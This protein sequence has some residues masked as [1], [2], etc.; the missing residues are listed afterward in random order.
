MTMTADLER[1]LT[2]AL[3]RGPRLASDVFIAEGAVVRGDVTLGAGSSVWFNAVMRGDVMPITIG[4]RTNIQDLCMVH[5]SS[6][7]HATQVGDDVTV[8][9]RAILHG[10]QVDQGCLIGMGAIVLDGAHVGAGSLVAA[11][12]LVPPGMQIP[13]HS[14]L[15][16]VPARIVRQ[17]TEQERAQFME[18]AE[19]YAAL[20]ARYAL[21]DQAGDGI[22]AI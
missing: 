1:Q 19:R 14:F 10:C 22:S 12:A 13:P 4:A 6:G 8:G 2:L 20:A 3:E 21:L 16:G 17:T 11:G 5:V 18:S 7:T 9:H 15:L